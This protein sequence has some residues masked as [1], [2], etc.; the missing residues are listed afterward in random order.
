[1]AKTPLNLTTL[2]SRDTLKRTL[3][4]VLLAFIVLFVI[5]VFFLSAQ[6]EKAHQQSINQLV[7]K[8]DSTLSNFQQQIKNLASNDLIINSIVDYSNRDNYLPIFF[9]SLKL[10]NN[11]TTSIVFTDFNG[12]IITG[13]NPELHQKNTEQINWKDEVLEQGK[14]V[15]NYSDTGLFVA[16]PVLLSEYPEGAIVAYID[17][18]QELIQLAETTSAL[19][20]L[21]P[22]NKVLYSSNNQLI[23]QGSTFSEK[24][25]SFW[26]SSE[27]AYLNGKVLLL[28]PPL[29]AYGDLLWIVILITISLVTLFFG[30]LANVNSAAK[31]AANSMTELHQTLAKAISQE[32]HHFVTT[33]GPNEPVEFIAIRKEFN[34]LL[35]NLFDQNISLEK[36]TSVINSL[37]EV[38]LVLDKDHN[39][40]LSNHSFKRFC[41]QT[42]FTPKKNLD[43]ILPK[44]H[45]VNISDTEGFEITYPTRH[46]RKDHK[47][48]TLLW[49]STHYVDEGG[50]VKGL[51][52]VGK[53]ISLAKQLEFDLRIK[54]QAFD[55]AQTSIVITESGNNQPIVYTN[56]AFSNLTGYSINEVIGKNCRFMQ[57]EKT[58]E[59]AIQQIKSAIISQQATTLTLTNY[60]K[61]GSEFKNELT[62]NP[63]I[64]E[65]GEVSHFLGIQ[66]DVT[67]REATA[68]YLKLAK[69]KAEESTQLKSE[70]LA[71]MSH[72]IRTPMNGVIGMLDLL[73]KGQLSDEQ[74]HNAE[75]AKN[76][77]NALL[78]IINDILDFSKIESGK[79]EI[80]NIPFDLPVL[81][82]EISQSHAQ[83]AHDKGLEFILDLHQID[84]SIVCSDA[85]RLRQVLNNLLNNAI[86]FTDKGKI[87]FSAKL[88]QTDKNHATLVCQ[89]EDTGIGIA[90]NRLNSVFD[91]FTQADSSTTRLYGGTG[92]GLAISAKLCQ[93]MHGKISVTS[94]ENKGSSF[95]LQI[96]ID[97]TDSEQHIPV[98]LS[99]SQILILDKEPDNLNT[100]VNLLRK[101]GASVTIESFA[102]NLVKQLEKTQYN[103]TFI[104]SSSTTTKAIDFL[105]A[106]PTSLKDKTTFTL[107]TK[108]NEIQDNDAISNAGF[109]H[110]LTKPATPSNL[111]R[112]L[113]S[114][115]SKEAKST[116]EL[117]EQRREKSSSSENNS[118]LLVEDNRTNQL[119]AKKILSTLGQD[120][121]IA[122][123]GQE[124]I[125]IL[126]KG[127]TAF[128]LIF[129]DCQMPVLDGYQTTENIRAG[130]AG[131]QN[132]HIPIIAMTANA[133]KGDKEKCLLHGM[134]DYISKPINIDIL[135]EKIAHH[136]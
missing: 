110:L 79:L 28:E 25:F 133:M 10:N 21:A 132:I 127:E 86:K 129:M 102:E 44:K 6:K 23:A 63:I 83:Q 45:L 99:N 71:S 32:E 91:S 70:F 66:I 54:N 130:A 111:K 60:K 67:E 17:N 4:S 119:V 124:A 14:P 125:E 112:V 88:I 35:N 15:F 97:I 72:E 85:G 105:A 100:L 106:I 92:L 16:E 131:K 59:A 123:N 49:N 11:S 30:L 120:V 77:A 103:M 122:N 18:L 73:L 62:I 8:L 9:R 46:N 128:S 20:Y 136:K 7:E 90:Q 34:T 107:M 116:I 56:K 118:V 1:M 47:S 36:F 126:I 22:N 81:L 41:Q 89:V 33:Q 78:T 108:A 3:P 80:E 39:I 74:Y 50:E 82:G 117:F 109:K 121:T 69:N 87:F 114:A 43:T 29:S 52:F 40:L 135:K 55:S 12:D 53:D 58:S 42:G 38:L 24:P 94:E 115:I 19:I 2:I 27:Q 57:G 93:L 65:Q 5:A 26:S 95:T 37:G 68:K 64:N 31:Y 98:D 134:D 84:Y 75:I 96:P 48:R 76:S 104:D 61:D 51:I 101:W 113:E 13:K